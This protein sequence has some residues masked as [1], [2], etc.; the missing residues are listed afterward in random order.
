MR[1]CHHY[2]GHLF[3]FAA[4]APPDCEVLIAEF[5][6]V[7]IFPET[8]EILHRSTAIRFIRPHRYADYCYRCNAACLRACLLMT[9]VSCA[10]TDEPI[11]MPFGMWTEESMCSKL[12]RGEWEG[13]S[14][15]EKAFLGGHTW[16]CPDLP[17]IDILNV[18]RQG[19]SAMATSVL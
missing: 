12:R 11:E 10:K 15:R 8:W 19:A 9:T 16:A 2:C 18:I 14:P 13:A 7:R 4:T 17:V 6:F 3:L 1:P 5:F